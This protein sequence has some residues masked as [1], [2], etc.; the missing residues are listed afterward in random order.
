[1]EA[2]GLGETAQTTHSAQVTGDGDGEYAE[3]VESTE[4][5][6]GPGARTGFDPT[7]VVSWPEDWQEAYGCRST[8]A[9]GGLCE[10][11]L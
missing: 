10:T 2:Y 3:C 6:P 7:E 9:G 5:V 8:R 1:M 11:D 4:G